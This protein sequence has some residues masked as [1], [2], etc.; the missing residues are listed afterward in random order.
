[1]T[2]APPARVRTLRG[3]GV[4]G[5]AALAAS[6]ALIVQGASCGHDFD[7]HLASWFDAL[8]SWRQGIFY[9]RWAPSPNYGA[10]EPRFIFYPPL[11]WMAGALLR[12]LVPWH[13]VPFVLTFLIFLATGLSTCALARQVL[14]PAPATFA[15]CVAIF[16]GYT[17]YTA[18]ERTAFGELT[19][20]FWIPLLLLFLLR[21]PDPSRQ[22][23]RRA[24][25][26]CAALLAVV[27]AG[28]W[29]SDAPLG[30]IAS[31][32]LAAMALLASL[33]RRTWVPIQRAVVA[34]ALGLGLA[35]IYL[36]PAY[37]E[38]SWVSIQQATDDPIYRIE[39]NW[40]FARHAAAYMRDHDAE[41]LKVSVISTTQ[42]LITLA[43]IAILIRRSAP[44]KRRRWWLLFACFPLADLFLQLPISL[45]V[46]NLF[47]R[48]RFLQFP[49]R[50]L[51]TLE[52]P[53]AICFAAVA[54]QLRPFARRTV[55]IAWTTAAL[56]LVTAANAGLLFYQHC[57]EEDRVRGM[58][59]TY[60]SGAGFEG[61]DEYAPRGVDNSI[62]ALKLPLACLSTSPFT[63]LGQA[64]EGVPPV[65]N[66]DQHSCDATVDDDQPTRSATEHLRIQTTALHAG[67]LILRLR[68]Y[69]AWQIRLNG[70]L[71][72][73]LPQR[74]DGL[75]VVPVPQGPVML[76]VDWTATPDVLIG[77][78]ITTIS[79]LLF[80]VLW[81][82]EH[83]PTA[84][85]VS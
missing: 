67:Y 81:F 51:V 44:S 84:P 39:N 61:T 70:V 60:L 48:L 52:A 29:L 72:H 41:L 63:V 28:A 14:A 25:D 56:L 20:G 82:I 65:W 80:G 19:G 66:P 74:D 49:W 5:L 68:R 62:A 43:C 10:G 35:A 59:A 75:I 30:L 79:L 45:S 24:L 2:A 71:Q 1:M 13:A 12:V 32:T 8:H 11:I 15:G 4:I 73:N 22:G 26:G 27:V 76:T 31:Y 6:L 38:Q 37:V 9:P 23:W 85:Q 21:E 42:L 47:P 55:L 53:M 7:F 50:W 83:R 78:G 16:S 36:V 69:P 40:L 34:T 57:D 18:Y 77:R 3:P 58:L 33:L 64:E 46:W 17:L 54:W